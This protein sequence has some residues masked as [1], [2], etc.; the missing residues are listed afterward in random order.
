MMNLNNENECKF[1]IK[2]INSSDNFYYYPVTMK[3][4]PYWKN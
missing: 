3:C 1:Q 4:T 2:C